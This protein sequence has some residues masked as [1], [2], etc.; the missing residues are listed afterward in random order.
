MLPVQYKIDSPPKFAVH[1]TL[2]YLKISYILT[3]YFGDLWEI[4]RYVFW[5]LY[6]SLI[7]VDIQRLQMTTLEQLLHKSDYDLYKF[8]A[9]HSTTMI[10]LS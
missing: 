9:E 8:G 10:W 1:I 5:P 3:E 2:R 7:K 4:T 6:I